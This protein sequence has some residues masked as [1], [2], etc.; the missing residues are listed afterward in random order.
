MVRIR[1]ACIQGG[2]YVFPYPRGSRC[3]LPDGRFRCFRV[4][5]RAAL[6]AARWAGGSGSLSLPP[7][8]ATC[9]SGGSMDGRRF[10]RAPKSASFSRGGRLKM[11]GLMSEAAPGTFCC[12]RCTRNRSLGRAFPVRIVN[13]FHPPKV[14]NLK[15][16]S[17]LADPILRKKDGPANVKICNHSNDQIDRKRDGQRQKGHRYVNRALDKARVK[18]NARMH[19]RTLLIDRRQPFLRQPLGKIGPLRLGQQCPIHLRIPRLSPC[20]SSPRWRYALLNSFAQASYLFLTRPEKSKPCSYP[21]KNNH[22]R[23]TV[24]SIHFASY[25]FQSHAH[26]SSEISC[27]R[28]RNSR[29]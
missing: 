28:G 9:A 6:F 5:L 1:P 27:L 19:R 12:A 14:D 22:A 16:L 13:G 25:L 4:V 23:L 11:A 10:G 2:A 21:S 3:R 24:G 15:E 26:S 7:K 20:S 8:R 17:V 29:G 18:G